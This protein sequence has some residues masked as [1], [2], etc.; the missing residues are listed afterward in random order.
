MRRIT[1]Y[2]GFLQNTEY[3]TRNK[4]REKNMNTQKPPLD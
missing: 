4:K 3:N 1:T 2:A